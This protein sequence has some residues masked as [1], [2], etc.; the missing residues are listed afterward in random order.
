MAARIVTE[1]MAATP[2][3]VGLLPA[4]NTQPFVFI[5]CNL[6]VWTTQMFSFLIFFLIERQKNCRY[7]DSLSLTL[8]YS[9]CNSYWFF[10]DLSIIK[11]LYK[12][13]DNN[14]FSFMLEKRFHL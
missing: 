5:T 14:F 12:T 10:R 2:P 4:W 9:F 13:I 3:L 1:C 11:V 6:R 7:T 8:C